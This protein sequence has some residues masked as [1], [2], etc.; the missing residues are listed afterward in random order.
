MPTDF[1]V[2]DE[3]DLQSAIDAIDV[4][5]TSA[6]ANTNY[7]ITFAPGLDPPRTR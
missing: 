3:A 7:Q 6:A 5:G 1:T 4:G 2:T